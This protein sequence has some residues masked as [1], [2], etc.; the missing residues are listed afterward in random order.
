MQMPSTFSLPL[1][2]LGITLNRLLPWAK[3]SNTCAGFLPR[4]PYSKLK[5]QGFCWGLVT[6]TTTR[7]H[8][9]NSRFLTWTQVFSAPGGQDGLISIWNN[10]NAEFLNASQGPGPKARLSKD[11]DIHPAMLTPVCSGGLQIP[12]LKC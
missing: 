4:E 12:V 9:W 6:G 7:H 2:N 10:P 1:F 5:V 11:G 3:F 8:Y